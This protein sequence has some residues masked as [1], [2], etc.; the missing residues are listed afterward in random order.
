MSLTRAAELEQQQNYKTLY[1]ESLQRSKDLQNENDLLRQQLE[2]RVVPPT[3]SST[4]PSTPF[5]STPVGN[6]DGTVP[7]A[8][9][10]KLYR[11]YKALDENFKVAKEALN[12]RRDERNRWKKFAATLKN[13]IQA[14]E[15]EH[16]ITIFNESC[17]GMEASM[18]AETTAPTMNAVDSFS[19]ALKVN[20]QRRMD[21]PQQSTTTAV[22]TEN[23]AQ[24]ETEKDPACESTQ[25]SSDATGTEELPTLQPTGSDETVRIKNEPSSDEPT[26]MWER[27]VKR[28]RDDNDGNETPCARVKQEPRDA[29]S[30]IHISSVIPQSQESLDLDDVGRPMM[31]PRKRHESSGVGITPLPLP[32]LSKSTPSLVST[33]RP[34]PGTA[35]K[36]HTSSVL[37]PISINRRMVQSGGDQPKLKAS[38]FTKGIAGV[39]DDAENR[40]S[41]KLDSNSTPSRTRLDTL[42]NTP[43][44]D[45]DETIS[46]PKANRQQRSVPA[47]PADLGVPQRRELPFDKSARLSTTKQPA[48]ARKAIS[49]PSPEKAT[50]TARKA[51]TS[52]LRGVSIADLKLDDFRINPA[53]NDGYDYAYSEVVRDRE[54]RACLSGCVDMHCCGKQ[55]RALAESQKPKPPLTP[56][57]RREEQKLLEDYLGDLAY[58]LAMMTPPEREETWL[59][60]KTQELA[61]KYG[62]HRHRY[63]RA[64]SPPGFWDADF[65]STQDLESDRAEAA[66]RERQA[67]AERYREAMRP[68]GRWIFRDE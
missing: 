50:P 54:E 49:N 58:K 25:D 42:L 65:P 9:H 6:S 14:A 21:P 60:A 27:P 19:E 66:K 56:E 64:R 31:T 29:S 2:K 4:D 39:T 38:F 8:A 55:F 20:Q 33:L 5:A 13:T 63:A 18:P 3:P 52:R 67:I 34:M 11:Q 57:Q 26:L 24:F 62:R 59:Q 7:I 17:H 61:D 12:R 51:R 40:R 37:T 15:S 30:P 23:Q 36:L 16:G 46:R 68:G 35:K 22:V 28:K 10:K 47:I 53:A 41:S 44:Q 45:V 48:S 43:V 32:S 1:E